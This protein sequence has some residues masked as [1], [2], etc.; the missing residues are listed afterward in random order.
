[1]CSICRSYQRR[2]QNWLQYVSGVA[3]L[4]VLIV[5]ATTWLWVNARSTFWYRDDVRLVSA[6]T[7]DAAV[8]VNWGDGEVFLS[9]LL[10]FMPGRTSDWIAPRL[11]FDERIP[12]GQFLRREF[13][14][15]KMPDKS[16]FVR[17]LSG[18]DFEKLISRAA[19]GE[20]CLELVF[21]EGSD[22]L[23]G[24]LKQF[25][26]PTLNTFKVGG[27]FQYWGLSRKTQIS[28]PPDERVRCALPR[29]N[30]AGPRQF[31]RSFCGPS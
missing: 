27:Y 17:G 30:R 4:M 29:R 15:S 28:V 7:L 20:N 1:M 16:E 5:T 23:L 3:A 13:P 22:S 26:G 18:V 9:H 11:I 31:G 2:W 14:K 25:A 12:N 8:A 24:E 21:F 19:N 6:N 10:F